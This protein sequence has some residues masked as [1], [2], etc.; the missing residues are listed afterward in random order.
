MTYFLDF[1][2]AVIYK[3]NKLFRKSLEE[4]LMY[5]EG[6]YRSSIMATNFNW[7]KPS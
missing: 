1:A 7:Q 2:V 5:D 6:G 3:N 4:C